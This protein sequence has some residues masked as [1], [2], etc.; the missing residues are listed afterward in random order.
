VSSRGAGKGDAAISWRTASA[1]AGLAHIVLPVR[2]LAAGKS[3]LSTVLDSAQREALNR[4]L[5]ERTLGVLGA[6]RGSL[7]TCVVVSACE[8]VLEVARVH[9]AQALKERAGDGLNGATALGVAH[10]RTHGASAVLVVPCDLP[11]LTAE[12][13]QALLDDAGGADLVIAPDKCGTGTNA[14]VVRTDLP[15]EFHF[16]E[17]SFASHLAQASARGASAAVH[18]SDALGFDVDTPDDFARWCAAFR[19]GDCDF[20][21]GIVRTRSVLHE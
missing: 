16:G 4:W 18:R 15:F 14:I 6:W 12:S 1:F 2:G 3:R 5:L 20:P 11:R 17:R 8:R 21:D 9:G 19:A 10:T 13:L 7:E